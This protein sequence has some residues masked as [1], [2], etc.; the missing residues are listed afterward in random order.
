MR[1]V[2]YLFKFHAPWSELHGETFTVQDSDAFTAGVRASYRV[3]DTFAGSAKRAAARAEFVAT[4]PSRKAYETFEESGVHPTY[5]ERRDAL[6]RDADAVVAILCA[7]DIA[8][9]EDRS[10]VAD[11]IDAKRQ[12]RGAA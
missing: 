8:A 11:E 3:S 1:V 4:F 7:E 5:A 6:G 12:K 9:L 10:D 2:I